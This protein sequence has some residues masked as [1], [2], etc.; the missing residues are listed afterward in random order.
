MAFITLSI[1]KISRLKISVIKF[2]DIYE[3]D[4]PR[5]AFII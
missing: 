1:K 5:N 2:P 3:P 4:I